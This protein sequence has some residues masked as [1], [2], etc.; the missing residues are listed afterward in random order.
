MIAR[1]QITRGGLGLFTLIFLVFVQLP[2]S[3]RAQATDPSDAYLQAYIT[4][5]DGVRLEKEGSIEGARRKY[6]Q[7]LSLFHGVTR[8]HPTWNPQMVKFRTDSVKKTLGQ[9]GSAVATPAPSISNAPATN[10]AAP[11]PVAPAPAAGG[12]LTSQLQSQFRTYEERI[13]QLQAANQQI[14]QER[15]SQTRLYQ[16][17]IGKIA[18]AKNSESTL[19]QRMAQ[20]EKEFSIA[21]NGSTQATDQLRKEKSALQAELEKA[22]KGLAAANGETSGLLAQ[23]EKSK[24]DAARF[25]DE[26]NEATR[27]RDQM[28]II[29]KTYENGSDQAV[30]DLISENSRLQKG[31]QSA[32]EDAESLR[33]E[34]KGK[35]VEIAQLKD[36]VQDV[37]T[38]LVA[39]N[40][41]ATGYSATIADLNTRLK[42]T[43]TMLEQ[44]GQNAELPEE[45]M[46]EN[47]LLRGLIVRQIRQQVRQQQT[48]LLVRSELENLEGSSEELIDRVA[49]LTDKRPSLSDA[50]RELLE[51]YDLAPTASGINSTMMAE[52]NPDANPEAARPEVP[53]NLDG[54]ALASHAEEAFFAKDFAKS[55]AYYEEFIKSDPSPEKHGMALA[56]LG[57]VRMRLKKFEAAQQSLTKARAL[58][59]DNSFVHF[60]LGMSHYWQGQNDDA[61]LA[62]ESAASL[63]P[64][65][66][67]AHQYTGIAAAR[68]GEF[69]KAEREFLEAI[70]LD[71]R[72]SPSHFNLAVLYATG[73]ATGDTGAYD[74]AE[75][76]YFKA[77]ENGAERDPLLERILN[78]AKSVAAEKAAADVSGG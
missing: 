44:D 34:N 7:S 54:P 42:A 11:N 9:L 43:M 18:T 59:P 56:N 31:L 70:A 65:N 48:N 51:K 5:Q 6:Q 46:A 23:L 63:D 30:K 2:T 10:Y 25:E 27:E 24:A 78:E 19:R 14:M 32:L 41:K 53:T 1:H 29:V 21:K 39:I 49:K 40:E 35:D 74:R 62:L 20:L 12:D 77:I 4:F 45:F 68:L 75:Q 26:R 28:A 13:R 33:A 73:T 22:T 38:Q 3:L 71:P 8:S 67:K 69:D 15:D 61:I 72:H 17:S 60:M 16:D 58:H 50:E 47:S 55:E 57:V 36:Q 64:D 76:H 66:L 52:A 37:R